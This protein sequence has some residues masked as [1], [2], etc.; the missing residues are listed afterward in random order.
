MSDKLGRN[1]LC[2]CGSGKKY[3]KCCLSAASPSFAFSEVLDFEWRKLRQLE[4]TVFDKHLIPYVMEVLPDD[5]MQLALADCLPEDLPEEIDRGMLFHQFLMPWI[6]FN[7][8][9]HEDFGLDHFEPTVTLAENYLH[10]QK[11]KLN[12]DEIRFI[13]AM[14]MT[15]YSFYAVLAVEKD[16]ALLVKDMLLSTEH[17]IKERQGT[18]YLKRGDIIFSRIVTLDN[19]SIFV[20][21]APFTLLPHHHTALLD[22]KK[23]LV[24]ENDDK[25][26]DS[27]A[28]R[29]KLDLALYDYFFDAII[30]AYNEPLP[31]LLNTDDELFQLT[32]TYFKL[33]QSPEATLNRLIAMTLSD[34]PEEFLQDAKRDKAGNITEIQFPWLK[35]GNKKHLSW[36]NTLYGDVILK[37][38]KL[39][40]KT[41]SVERAE[42]GKKLLVKL[43]GKH[44]EFQKML[45][46]S[47]QQKMQ[48]LPKG[49]TDH[50]NESEPNLMNVP[51]IQAQMKA[52]AKAHWENWFDQ[53]IPALGSKTPRE[54]AKTKAGREQ[55]EA[56]LLQFE[57]M[58]DK[59]DKND[60]FRAD[61]NFIK[62][63]LKLEK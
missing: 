26:L 59:K 51:E 24:E 46:E 1:D 12:R 50:P 21:M 7:W 5:V 38:G 22:F 6:F 16:Q 19:Q 53:S 41:N 25:P 11:N 52:M 2:S 49:K 55:L 29:N 17:R 36:D 13:E 3:K 45:I 30:Q 44:I 27:N 33:T 15:F 10:Y 37:E 28:L 35:K 32:T 23:W 20:G 47:A 14:N 60:P 63:V 39:I 18:H 48:S 62:T 8:L 4:G 61:I 42:K 9:P 40:L 54:A 56:L 31:I 43:L 58:D 57:R 34:D